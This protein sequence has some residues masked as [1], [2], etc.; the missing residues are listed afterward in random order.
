MQDRKKDTDTSDVF[1]CFYF[2]PGGFTAYIGIETN[3][4][5]EQTIANWLN[6]YVGVFHPEHLTAVIRVKSRK[7]FSC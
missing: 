3:K 6:A 2:I 1:P 7:E 5:C 4:L